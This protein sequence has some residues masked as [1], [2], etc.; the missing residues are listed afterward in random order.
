M[1]CGPLF[2]PSIGLSLLKAGLA[3]EGIASRIHYFTVRFAGLTG[4]RFYQGIA[5]GVRPSVRYQAGEW[6]FSAALFDGDDDVRA[7]VQTILHRK[8]S[9]TNTRG[10]EVTP[11][12]ENRI[13]ET[14]RMAAE[15]VD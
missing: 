14:R 3:R 13:L 12:L 6:I 11:A 15:S 2:A 1:P 4:S 5:N 10:R 7:Y 8:R 9:R